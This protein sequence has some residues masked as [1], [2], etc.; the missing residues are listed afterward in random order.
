MP[1]SQAGNRLLKKKS[2]VWAD[3]ATVDGHVSE[4][5]F[6]SAGGLV[7]PLTLW[8]PKASIVLHQI[9][10]EVGTLAV[11]GWA[12]TLGTASRG[13]GGLI[14]Y[15]YDGSLLC[16]FNIAIKGLNVPS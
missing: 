14:L 16:G 10:N 5:W 11:D 2:A 6:P 15:C 8:T 1:I 7:C 3:A 4:P 9:I 12:V 13:L